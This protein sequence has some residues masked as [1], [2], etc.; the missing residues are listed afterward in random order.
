M[1]ELDGDFYMAE[2]CGRCGEKF[3]TYAMQNVAWTDLYGPLLCL[4]C[5]GK[6][7]AAEQMHHTEMAEAYNRS[8][9][10][11]RSSLGGKSVQWDASKVS[12]ITGS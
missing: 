3:Y 8:R 10:D 11:P 12:G 5:Q 1:S 6:W 2:E 7:S 4:W 9:S